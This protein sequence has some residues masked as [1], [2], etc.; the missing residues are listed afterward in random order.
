M[1]PLSKHTTNRVSSPE[2]EKNLSSFNKKREEGSP[3]RFTEKSPR[4][5]VNK[6]SQ[7]PYKGN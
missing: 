1:Y 3:A 2:R 6:R 5:S 7:S 4:R